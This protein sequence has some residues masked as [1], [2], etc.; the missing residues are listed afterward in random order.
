MASNRERFAAQ[1]DKIPAGRALTKL[2]NSRILLRIPPHL[3]LPLSLNDD[4]F[5]LLQIILIRAGKHQDLRVLDEIRRE[6]A[7]SEDGGSETIRDRAKI[8]VDSGRR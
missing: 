5:R 3:V 7:G 6:C 2:H 1:R 4:V 8:G